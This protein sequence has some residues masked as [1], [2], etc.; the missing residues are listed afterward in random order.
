MNAEPQF[1]A[2][3]LAE[4]AALVG[5][6]PVDDDWLTAADLIDDLDVVAS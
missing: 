4:T 3:D 1:T 6:A 2:A 5:D